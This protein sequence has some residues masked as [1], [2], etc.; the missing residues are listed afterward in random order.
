[1]TGVKPIGL[2]STIF[3]AASPVSSNTT[4]TLTGDSKNKLG[5]LSVLVHV[6]KSYLHV[7]DKETII[8]RVGDKNSSNAITSVSGRITSPSGPFKKVEGTT[9][10]KGN[11]SYS[12]TVSNGDTCGK[13]K[14][15][16]GVSAS[17]YKKYLASKTFSVTP[18]SVT[19]YGN[20]NNNHP[21]TI[22]PS[23]SSPTRLLLS[24]PET[25]FH[26]TQVAL[27]LN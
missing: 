16:I 23:A 9:D 10:N 24:P 5:A 7:G 14:L 19:V 18:I 2:N 27:A 1:M 17:G 11:A 20:T 12:W 25:Q 21:P 15:I 22:I 13:Y 3:T 26:Q 6:E 8:I 4:S